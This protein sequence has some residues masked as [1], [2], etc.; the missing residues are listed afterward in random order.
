M[1]QAKAL[2]VLKTGTNVFLTG[3]P[4]SGKTH[5]ANEYVAYLRAHGIDVA[6]T[7]STGIA[8]THLGGMT[9]HSWSGIGIR[10]TLDKHDLDAIAK[11]KYV[12][13]RVK[14]ASVLIIEEVSMLPG[15]TV[16]L[17]DAVCKRIR[18]NA[19][20]FGGLQV[21]FVGDF[22]QLP[23]IM[24]FE[25]KQS[26]Q[27]SLIKEETL[28]RFTYDAQNWKEAQPT[29]CYLTEQHRQDDS[30]FLGV[31]SAIRRNVFDD[32]HM[33]SLITRKIAYTAAPEGVPKLFSHNADVDRVNDQILAKL[34]GDLHVCD[35]T[36][37]G[38][39]FLVSALQKWCLSPAALQLKV[40][41]A[42]MFTKNNQKEGFVNGSLGIVEGFDR[43][44]GYPNV[45][46]RNGK[47]IDVEPMDWVIEENGETR[48]KIT[49]I[50]LRLAWAITVHKSQ[51][52]SLDE[53]VVDLA[54]VFEYGQGYVALSRV[55]RLSGLHLLGWN[56]RAFQVHP[57][58]LVQDEQFRAQSE[59]AV[60]ELETKSEDEIQAMHDRFV[61]LCGGIIANK[62]KEKREKNDSKADGFAKIRETFASAYRPWDEEQDAQLRELFLEGK[63]IKELAE[64]FSR[65]KGSIRARLM[66]FS[67]IESK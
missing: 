5:T 35:M 65:T 12:A 59:V 30:K 47:R 14:R 43:E 32:S 66:K 29:I 40:G 52:M 28:S 36:S 45:K 63:S 64:V 44:T 49:Q 13:T 16:A 3:E 61:Q 23:P 15:S 10:G 7:A 41:A 21:V 53:A 2:A 24:K 38:P 31:L 46:L 4:G 39:D 8:A 56:T 6:I 62:S 54:D 17:V 18:K 57:E 48:A 9:I 34:S 42:V 67:L 25:V 58:V 26:S 20:P 60:G 55:R 50:P 27:L 1:T 22:F 33:R 51:G 11:S 37:Y 19:M